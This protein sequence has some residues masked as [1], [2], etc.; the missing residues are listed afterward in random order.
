MHSAEMSRKRPMAVLDTQ[1]TDETPSNNLEPASDS[2]GSISPLVRP[3]LVE[4]APLCYEDKAVKERDSCDY[5]IKITMEMAKK[6]DAP[7]KVRVYA[8]GIYDLFHQGH[9]RQ[10]LQCKT[11]F[12][13][14][15]VYLLVG[16]C[17]DELTH[18]HK[19]KT[20]M[21]ENER[22]EA[23]RH[24]R[25]VDE[26][27]VNAP[28][29]L[30]D[31]FLDK[32]KIDFVAHDELPYTTGSAVDVYKHIKERGMFAVTQRTEGVSTSDIVSRIVRDYDTY[33][34]R[35]L[36]RGYSRQDLNVSFLRGQK[37][38]LQNKVDEFKNEAKEKIHK[39]EEQS[40][41]MIGSF[42][43]LFGPA[44]IEQM[45]E[46]G[47]DRITRA[48]SPGPSP[49]GSRDNSPEPGV[50]EPEEPPT[51]RRRRTK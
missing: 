21:D 25:Y 22:Y 9:A 19:G 29:S 34:R 28:W 15:E 23:L 51:K 8:D 31:E 1:S 4:P 36:A 33:V 20:V 30:S 24:C 27:V 43:S 17:N 7:R 48:M 42:L 49:N 26:I 45:W 41:E 2:V 44:A 10:L 38:K 14:S 18:S 39:W 37:C 5:S 35:N 40:K 32:Y 3:S 16:C 47:K 46:A 50:H 12:P 11:L 13:D 6:G